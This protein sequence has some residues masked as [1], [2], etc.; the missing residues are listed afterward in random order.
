MQHERGLNVYTRDESDQNT[1]SRA[2]SK[3]TFTTNFVTIT[4]NSFD[5]DSQ[6]Q[7]NID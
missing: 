4:I 2:G 5:Q 1:L 3:V 7:V 6:A